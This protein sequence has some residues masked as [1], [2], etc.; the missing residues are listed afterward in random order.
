MQ[1][2]SLVAQTVKNPPANAGN[3]REPGSIPGSGRA[4]GEGNGK[5]LQYCCLENCVDRGAWRA[6]VQGVAESW[7]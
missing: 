5:P 1:G 4:P 7:T 6:A 2:A 3:E